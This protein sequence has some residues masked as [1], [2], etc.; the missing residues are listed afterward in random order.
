MIFNSFWTVSVQT[1]QIWKK[2]FYF[3][4]WDLIKNYQACSFLLANK[5]IHAGTCGGG[6][7]DPVKNRLCL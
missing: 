2:L 7:E 1:L 5:Y 6:K 3:N 4:C